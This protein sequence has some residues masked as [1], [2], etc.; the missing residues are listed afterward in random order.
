MA[1]V[2]IIEKCPFFSSLKGTQLIELTDR[3]TSREF[4][5]GEVLMHVGDA[6]D[7]LYLILQGKVGIYTDDNRLLDEVTSGNVIGESAIQNKTG[8][9]ATVKAHC[10]IQTLILTYDDFDNMAFQVKLR[11]F[12]DVANFLASIDYFSDWSLS[13]L[14]RLA[15][16]SIIKQYHKSQIIYSKGEFARDL[17]IVKQG[18]IHLQLDLDI[19]QANKWPTAA[20]QWTCLHTTKRY[21]QTVRVCKSGSI[22]GEQE[23]IDNQPLAFTAVCVDKAVLCIVRDQF[24]GEI[25]SEKDRRKL[26]NLT[27]RPETKEIRYEL[28]FERQK[29]K[30][31]NSA[32]LDAINTNPVPVGRSL[33]D[34]HGEEKRQLWARNLI[35]REKLREKKGV[36]RKTQVVETIRSG[37]LSP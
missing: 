10:D 36:I 7:C 20:N 11:D 27:E 13:K 37:S 34:L 5:M 30:I 31:L 33:H 12:Y 35:K 22:F 29:E 17:Y 15:S 14:Y 18:E 2:R 28:E 8:R 4:A 9:T 6:A 1:V 32:L 16:V 21:R 25:F 24:F 3:M 23:L 26:Y 19:N